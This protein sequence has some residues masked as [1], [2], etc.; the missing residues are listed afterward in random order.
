MLAVKISYE[1]RKKAKQLF[2]FAFQHISCNH[3][4]IV[5]ASFLFPSVPDVETQSERLGA[6]AGEFI[7]ACSLDSAGTKRP[8]PPASQSVPAKRAKQSSSDVDLAQSIKNAI[9]NNKVGVR[10]K[11]IRDY[12]ISR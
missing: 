3:L 8:T 4:I 11:K 6:L 9:Q 5:K 1:S 10:I 2:L 12:S 7:S